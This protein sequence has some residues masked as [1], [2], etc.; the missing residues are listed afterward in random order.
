MAVCLML[1]SIIGGAWNVKITQWGMASAQIWTMTVPCG[2]TAI[3][4]NKWLWALRQ[5]VFGGLA[6]ANILAAV[7]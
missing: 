7:K 5:I 2:I 4:K 3:N 1:L 6:A